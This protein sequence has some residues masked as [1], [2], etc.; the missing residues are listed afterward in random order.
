M[1]GAPPKHSYWTRSF[2]RESSRNIGL[3][4]VSRGVRAFGGTL[5][6]APMIWTPKRSQ[7]RARRADSG[8][9]RQPKHAG[10]R[11]RLD[12]WAGFECAL[13]VLEASF[14]WQTARCLG[15]DLL[16]R[17]SSMSTISKNVLP[18]SHVSERTRRCGCRFVYCAPTAGPQAPCDQPHGSNASKSFDALGQGVLNGMRSARRRWHA[19]A[20][21]AFASLRASARAVRRAVRIMACA[22]RS[23]RLALGVRHRC[24][25]GTFGARARE[26]VASFAGKLLRDSAAWSELAAVARHSHAKLACVA[27]GGSGRVGPQ[28]LTG[29][30]IGCIIAVPIGDPVSAWQQIAG[31]ASTLHNHCAYRK[32]SRLGQALLASTRGGSYESG[33]E[34]WCNPNWPFQHKR[35]LESAAAWKV[36]FFCAGSGS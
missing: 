24:C 31:A 36:P 6:F 35:R 27:A 21:C 29:G 13:G 8:P 3:S 26:A 34:D 5:P 18:F 17:F 10:S 11:T 12:A 14:L 4:H 16:A 20:A 22:S 7:R 33:L 23:S 32:A 15:R 19:P 30:R 25:V 9:T 2:R 1:Q 28:L